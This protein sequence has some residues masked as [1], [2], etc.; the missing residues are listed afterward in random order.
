MMTVPGRSLPIYCTTSRAIGETPACAV[1]GPYIERAHGPRAIAEPSLSELL[2][3]F[4][5]KV[6]A[7]RSQ[8][9]IENLREREA[10]DGAIDC[11]D[12][13]CA[14][15]TDVVF[16]IPAVRLADAQ[17]AHAPVHQYRFDWRS[18]AFGG[19][20]GAAHAVEIPFVFHMVGDHRLHVLI[21]PDAPT[22]LADAMHDSW[23]SFARSGVPRTATMN[24]WPSLPVAATERPLMLFDTEITL[25]ED[26]DRKSVV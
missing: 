26:P 19:M 23:V 12:V 4:C 13:E 24:T 2:G 22:E 14:L 15:L 9:R 7:T 5:S 25:V 11:A 8:V 18:P 16:R 17:V 20:I 21:G 10:F 1:R 3:R 6:E